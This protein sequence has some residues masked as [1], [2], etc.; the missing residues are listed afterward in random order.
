MYMKRKSGYYWVKRLGRWQI[1][2]YCDRT[3]LWSLYGMIFN[4]R[5]QEFQEISKKIIEC[6]FK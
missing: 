5:D 2:L 1:S 6:P 3:N 4:F